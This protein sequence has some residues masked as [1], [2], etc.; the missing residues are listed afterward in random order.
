MSLTS[1]YLPTASLPL[2]YVS[3]MARLIGALLLP[4]N[5]RGRYRF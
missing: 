5:R 2:T 1:H 3:Q 4:V